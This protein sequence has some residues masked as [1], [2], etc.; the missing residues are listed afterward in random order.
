MLRRAII[1]PK[2]ADA[3]A[4]ENR[5]TAGERYR[6]ACKGGGTVKR[7][8]VLACRFAQYDTGLR[9]TH[10]G[11]GAPSEKILTWRCKDIDDLGVP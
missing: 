9:R 4:S 5:E 10:V 3:L 2:A 8:Q 7:L 1:A 6:G 11:R